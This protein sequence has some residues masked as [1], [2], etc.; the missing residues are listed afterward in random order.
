MLDVTTEDLLRLSDLCLSDASPFEHLNNTIRTF[1][2]MTP[3]KKS[4]SIQNDVITMNDS[5]KHE[6]GRNEK[7][8]TNRLARL[9]GMAFV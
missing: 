3:M 9:A 1:I 7:L 4:S 8:L 5:F 6:T 2:G